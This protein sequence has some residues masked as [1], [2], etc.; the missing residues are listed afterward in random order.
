[1]RPSRILALL[2]VASHALAGIAV[3]LAALPGPVGAGL[4]AALIASLIVA[5]RRAGWLGGA[6]PVRALRVDVQGTM[7]IHDGA[8]WHEAVVLPSSRVSPHF[9]LPHFRLERFPRD[10]AVLSPPRGAEKRLGRPGAFLDDG[11]VLRPPILPDSLG[12]DDYR[13]LSVWLRWRR[14]DAGEPRA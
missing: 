6:M 3:G 5:L 11:R 13:R 4:V 9:M 12:P 2:L 1:L 10:F 14:G 7:S 8:G